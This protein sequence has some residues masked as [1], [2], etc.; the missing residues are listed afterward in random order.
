MDRDFLC[1]KGLLLG[2]R[3]V[4]GRVDEIDIFLI[5]PLLGQPKGLAEAHKMELALNAPFDLERGA[6]G[7]D[8]LDEL[9]DHPPLVLEGQGVPGIQVV[10]DLPEVDLLVAAVLLDLPLELLL[11]DIQLADPSADI[12][13][14]HIIGGGQAVHQGGDFCFRLGELDLQGG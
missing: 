11:S 12:A 10:G 14:H 13:V 4:K 1:P 2:G 9:V 5:H 3:C 7:M 6:G 8:D